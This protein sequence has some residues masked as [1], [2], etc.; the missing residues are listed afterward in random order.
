MRIHP[1]F[2]RIPGFK[3]EGCTDRS[4]RNYEQQPLNQI[5]IFLELMKVFYESVQYKDNSV[6]ECNESCMIINVFLIKPNQ[7]TQTVSL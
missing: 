4:P 2:Q 6:N 7:N 5:I 3:S 1:E